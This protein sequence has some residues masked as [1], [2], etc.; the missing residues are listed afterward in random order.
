[1]TETVRNAI[2]HEPFTANNR[3]G[4][5]KDSARSAGHLIIVEDGIDGTEYPMQQ[6][7]TRHSVTLP[8]LCSDR[9][10]II[11]RDL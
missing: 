9:P 7:V 3:A 4:V 11:I 5:R 1:M 6:A 2:L 8:A 10:I